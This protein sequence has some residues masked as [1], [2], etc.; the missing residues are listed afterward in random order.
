MQIVRRLA[1]LGLVFTAIA[2]TSA[3]GDTEPVT[4]VASAL[5]AVPAIAQ[6]CASLNFNSMGCDRQ[7]DFP[8]VPPFP[9]PCHGEGVET[10]DCLHCCAIGAVTCR[11]GFVPSEGRGFLE[12]V[13]ARF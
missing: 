3:E 13:P 4:H 2:C 8:G 12:C 6:T 9:G 7:P 1:C 10:V 11:N 5:T